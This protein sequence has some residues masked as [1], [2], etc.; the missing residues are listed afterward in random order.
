MLFGCSRATRHAPVLN[1]LDSTREVI[2]TEMPKEPIMYY[3]ILFLRMRRWETSEGFWR[4]CR[5]QVSYLKVFI[6]CQCSVLSFLWSIRALCWFISAVCNSSYDK[7]TFEQKKKPS[8]TFWEIHSLV[9]STGVGCQDL[10]NTHVCTLCLKLPVS[11][12]NRTQL[13]WLCL[14]LC[15]VSNLK[16]FFFEYQFVLRYSMLTDELWRCSYAEYLQTKPC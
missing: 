12:A 11:L 6:F 16:L 10:Y 7:R 3:F 5:I 9:F 14:N 13:I 1:S 15:S 8:Q 4:F 2:N